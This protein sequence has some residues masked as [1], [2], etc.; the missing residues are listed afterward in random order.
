V[1]DPNIVKGPWTEA[2]DQCL[3][4]LVTELGPKVGWGPCSVSTP[5]SSLTPLIKYAI[6]ETSKN[7]KSLCFCFFFF[8]LSIC[9]LL[10]FVDFVFL[11]RWAAIA[12]QLP[13][14]IAKQC[15]ERWHNHLDPGICKVGFPLC[16][17][18]SSKLIHSFQC[19]CNFVR[20]FF[21]FLFSI[22]N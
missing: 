2:E 4:Q 8:K 15:R 6:V 13:G 16:M 3:R 12:Q 18:I 11:K 10:L 5:P 21:F 19:A 14:R 9:V 7:M 22:K 20:D 1:L 17:Y